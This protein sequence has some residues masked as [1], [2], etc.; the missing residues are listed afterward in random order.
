MNNFG[1]EVNL[2]TGRTDVTFTDIR[3]NK[4]VIIELKYNTSANVAIQQ[5]KDKQYA[6]ELSS[7]YP[8][9]IIGINLRPTKIVDVM[10]KLIPFQGEKI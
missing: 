10:T 2:G 1:L 3:N 6:V 9:I 8:V 4:A 7:K 5:I